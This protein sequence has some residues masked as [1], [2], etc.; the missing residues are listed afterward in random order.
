MIDPIFLLYI[1][2]V[3]GSALIGVFGVSYWPRYFLA[4]LPGVLILAYAGAQALLLAVISLLFFFVLFLFARK[5]SSKR[6]KNYLPYLGLTTLLVPDYF[7]AWE[8]GDLLFIGSA[9]FI[10]R[11]FVTVKECIKDSADIADY[12][13]SSVI[14][15]FFFASLFT[16]PV[17][18]GYNVHQQLL[19]KLPGDLRDGFF[20]VLEGFAFILPVS[21]AVNYLQGSIDLLQAES[22]SWLG[23]IAYDFLAD[24][25]LAFIFVFTT[26]FGYSKVAEGV[27][28]LMGFEVPVN[29]NQPHKST[30][31]SNFWQRWHRSMADF[32][33]KYLYF[34][35]SINLRNP[36]LG[37]FVAF[38]FMGLW[39]NLSAGYFVWGLAH[40]SALIWLQPIVSG[41][42]FP[43]FWARVITLTFVVY[44]SYIANYVLV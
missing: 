33:M 39:H 14:A 16:G 26:F 29:F 12:A 41:P 35:I 22:N 30:S 15:T 40:S 27:A 28:N 21:Q 10:I 23:M 6:V 20:K 8:Q 25:I 7:A 37:L 3:T 9:F 5:S 43:V 2:L 11:Q 38:V 36:K 32:V 24:P 18:S 44:I 1:I 31:F 13:R 17:F 42:G 34:P 19:K 4:V